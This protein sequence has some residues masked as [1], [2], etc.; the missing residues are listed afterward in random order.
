MASAV[1]V[2]LLALRVGGALEVAIL[3][4]SLMRS[5]LG[6]VA[7]LVHFVV[8]GYLLFWVLIGIDPG[9]PRVPYPILVILHLARRWRTAFPAS[10]SCRPPPSSPPAGTRR[11]TPPG[12]R[13]CL[14]DQKLGAGIAWAFGEIP[15]A[16]VMVLLVRSGSAPTSAN[17]LVLIALAG[18][19]L[20]TG[21]D[22][23]GRIDRSPI[24]PNP[25]GALTTNV[26]SA[27]D[28]PA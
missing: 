13:P 3:L 18:L 26:R 27:G 17:A 7:M 19:S 15:A 14:S 6:H 12:R 16:V 28:T 11:P 9:R 20:G 22:A 8:S 2:L 10:R 23:S 5:H 21:A 24:L 25:S 1:A 4:S